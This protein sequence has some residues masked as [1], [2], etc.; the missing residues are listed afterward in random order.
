MNGT[1]DSGAARCEWVS[2]VKRIRQSQDQAAF[3]ELFQ[4]FAPR[5]KAFLIRSGSDA[6]LAED[7][8]Q[9]VMATLWHK[10]HLFDPLRVTVAT[11]VVTIARTKRIDAILKQR[12]PEPE[13]LTWG[14]EA[15]LEQADVVA[16]QQE[17]AQMCTALLKLPEAQRELI[18]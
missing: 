14:P 11:W 2:H 13:E 15:E 7:C 16:M 10:A 18:V 4:H 3:A 8:A 5:V 12:R 6:T 17:T 9:E 1:K